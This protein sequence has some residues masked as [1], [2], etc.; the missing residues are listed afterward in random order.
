V[1]IPFVKGLIQEVD[2]ENK[3]LIVQAPEGLIAIYL[4]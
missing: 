3:K 2:R 1:L 4:G